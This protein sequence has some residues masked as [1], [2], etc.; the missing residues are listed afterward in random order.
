M[1]MSATRMVTNLDYE[2][3]SQDDSTHLL[4]DQFKNQMEIL[5]AEYIGSIPK[6]YFV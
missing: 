3:V 6:N 4:D 2:N 5:I 1:I